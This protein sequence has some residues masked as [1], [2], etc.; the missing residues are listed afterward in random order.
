MQFHSMRPFYST[1]LVDFQ[2]NAQLIMCYGQKIEML[3]K[4]IRCAAVR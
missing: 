1:L 3:K 4:G 2:S